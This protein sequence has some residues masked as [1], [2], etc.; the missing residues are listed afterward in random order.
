[1]EPK[2][3]SKQLGREMDKLATSV[4]SF[5]KVIDKKINHAELK[6]RSDILLKKIQSY[7]DFI[8]NQKNASLKTLELRKKFEE[9][10]IRLKAIEEKFKNKGEIIK[11]AL[12][13]HL[14]DTSEESTE[15]LHPKEV[16]RTLQRVIDALIALKRNPG[17]LPEGLEP[18]RFMHRVNG[19][20]KNLELLKEE[21]HRMKYDMQLRDIVELMSDYAFDASLIYDEVEIYLQTPPD[22]RAEVVVSR[23][24]SWIFTEKYIGYDT[25]VVMDKNHFTRMINDC[26]TKHNIRLHE[27]YDDFE[28]RL[29]NDKIFDKKSYATTLKDI[30]TLPSKLDEVFGN[31][32][33]KMRVRLHGVKLVFQMEREDGVKYV[34]GKVNIMINMSGS[35]AEIRKNFID[36][37]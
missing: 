30:A 11:K 4:D 28:V 27:E 20:I 10:K 12:P 34:Q 14:I 1:M 29:R 5:A 22:K 7:I 15:C 31:M 8:D 9:L 19:V 18:E 16:M 6:K 32:D 26:F 25:D 2:I 13:S 36:Y 33:E 17:K 23:V 37:L 3:D 21:E 35:A 24:K